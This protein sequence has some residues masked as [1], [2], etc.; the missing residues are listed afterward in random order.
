MTV[1]GVD[2][3]I[4]SDVK[5]NRGEATLPAG[6]HPLEGLRRRGVHGLLREHPRQHRHRHVD[7]R[8]TQGGTARPTQIVQQFISTNTNTLRIDPF[9]YS[10]PPNNPD[11]FDW[12][13]A[14]QPPPPPPPAQELNLNFVDIDFL[15]TMGMSPSPP[16]TAKT[17][18]QPAPIT[19]DPKQILAKLNSKD[20]EFISAYNA[21]ALQNREKE[22]KV[23][24]QP[25]P[26]KVDFSSLSDYYNKD[27]KV[28]PPR[29]EQPKPE[30]LKEVPSPVLLSGR[31]VV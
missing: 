3:V 10:A 1:D 22:G 24:K 11:P 26:L 13:R 18:S 12:D 21:A 19:T 6:E 16:K 30:S 9:T 17:Q 15:E 4:I 14:F 25:E 2:L 23:E 5:A 31:D 27:Q 29:G 20:S 8:R 7:P 28:D